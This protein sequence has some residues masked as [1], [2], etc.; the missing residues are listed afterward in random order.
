MYS[1]PHG[2]LAAVSFPLCRYFTSP[3]VICECKAGQEDLVR[4]LRG[5]L[6]CCGPENLAMPRPGNLLDRGEAATSHWIWLWAVVFGLASG[7][8]FGGACV[9][10]WLRSRAQVRP[11]YPSGRVQEVAALGDVGPQ[12]G[13]PRRLPAVGSSSHLLHRGRL[14]ARQ[15]SSG[16][17]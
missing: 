14:G 6:D 5:R 17:S 1:F 16:L 4:I 11:C 7:L 3:R 2:I 9:W 10:Y 8:G 13:V 15:D 12:D